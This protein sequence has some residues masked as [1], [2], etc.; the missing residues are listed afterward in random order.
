MTRSAFQ[1][2]D[3]TLL[4]A[5]LEPGY[6]TPVFRDKNGRLIEPL[7]DFCDYYLKEHRESCRGQKAYRTQLEHVAYSMREYATF[8]SER[9]VDWRDER[10]PV[11]PRIA[12]R[13]VNHWLDVGDD[14]LVE[15]R[16]HSLVRTQENPR[17]RGSLRKAMKTVNIKLRKI[18]A[19]YAWA[20]D[21]ALFASNLIGVV[22]DSQIR[23]T[24]SKPNSNNLKGKQDAAQYPKCFRF[25]GT[26][27]RA[28]D[29]QYWATP[30]DLTLIERFFHENREPLTAVRNVL[31]LRL[32]QY[33]GWRG[34]SAN[35]L[36]LDLFSDAAISA[37]E[38][39]G[40]ADFL[41]VPPKQ[42]NFH[43]FAFP[44]PWELAY[45]IQA[46]I[47]PRGSR[48]AA[49]AR[50]GASEFK[51][52]GHIFI[53]MTNGTPLTDRALS[54]EF[55]KAFRHIGAP[56]GAGYHAVRRGMSEEFAEQVIEARRADGRSTAREDVTLELAEKLGHANGCALQ[57]YLRAMG[58]RRI[59]TVAERQLEE[60]IA[61]DIEIAQ[62]QAKLSQ[63]QAAMARGK[64]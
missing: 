24:L 57:A 43:S 59:T 49:M 11:D 5:E 62:L 17:S 15:F 47:A 41:V 46:Y 37:Q 36:T 39:E 20:Q 56:K 3:V 14:F 23:S 12:A 35:S 40:R 32:G 7:T 10:S 4:F 54:Q 19:F 22:T 6:R 2:P 29:A 34:E 18:Y 55:G 45:A 38:R 50:I 63:L 52:E 8:C 16:N 53:S 51:T 26:N 27:S 9:S 30:D 61:K 48:S 21:E 58:K 33:V 42:K 60:L 28:S 1:V 25:I 31:L 13:P 64:P 44:V